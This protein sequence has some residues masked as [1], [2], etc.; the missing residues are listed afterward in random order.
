MVIRKCRS[1]MVA[2]AQSR[3]AVPSTAER[4]NS[5]IVVISPRDMLR[6]ASADIIRILKLV[7]LRTIVLARV[8][9]DVVTNLPADTEY[10]EVILGKAINRLP[11]ENAF[12]LPYLTEQILTALTLIRL[13]KKAK[14]LLFSHSLMPLPLAVGRILRKKALVYS[15]GLFHPTVPTHRSIMR[16][17]VILLESLYYEWADTILTVSPSLVKNHLLAR[18]RRKTFEAPA[19]LL[20]EDFF[21]RFDFSLPSFR[22]NVV[23]FIGRQS[24]EK[25]TSE[26]AEAIS[27]VGDRNEDIEFLI[28][29][30]DSN[31]CSVFDSLSSR[32]SNLPQAKRKTKV[33]PWVNDVENCYKKIKL[34]VIPSKSEGLP[35]VLLEAIACGTLVLTT[36]VG[37]LADFITDGENGFVLE[38]TSPI[39]IANRILKVLDTQAYLLDRISLNAYQFLRQRYDKAKILAS[40]RFAIE[41]TLRA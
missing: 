22:S 37:G 32:K 10:S 11:K 15:G 38:N 28:V 25:G 16:A 13:S 41:S 39:H 1:H 14:L 33:M 34:L 24:W 30:G 35:S 19:R 20:D 18:H 36:T 8:P 31:Q 2:S 12:F 23:G 17:F 5:I 7:G 27:L 21:A 9:A 40:W 3:S 4:S 6:G 26:F 29:G